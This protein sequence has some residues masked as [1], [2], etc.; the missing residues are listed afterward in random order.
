MNILTAILGIIVAAA[1]SYVVDEILKKIINAPNRRFIIDIVVF[2][3]ALG[4]FALVAFPKARDYAHLI[5]ASPDDRRCYFS[6]IV[7]PEGAATKKDANAFD[8]PV[9]TPIQWEPNNCI[10]VVQSYQNAVLIKE[11]KEQ[12]SEKVIIEQVSSTG[13]TEIKIFREGFQTESSSVW[14]NLTP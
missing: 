9:N 13:L 3:I 2:L 4:I 10:M 14:V 11:L 5:V 12:R 7:K 1:I 6:K 8:T